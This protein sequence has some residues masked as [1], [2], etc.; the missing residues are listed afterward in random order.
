MHTHMY[1]TYSY[2][3]R[4]RD[5]LA[6][7]LFIRMYLSALFDFMCVILYIIPFTGIIHIIREKDGLVKQLE[8]YLEEHE[9]KVN[10][11][12]YKVAMDLST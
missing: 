1:C 3:Y 6:Y 10:F 9:S 8:K 12:T 2:V 5:A 11:E 7:T 4:C